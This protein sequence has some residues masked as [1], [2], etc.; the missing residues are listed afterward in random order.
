MPSWPPTSSKI[1][2]GKIYIDISIQRTEDNLK[3]ISKLV[4]TIVQERNALFC[5]TQCKRQG[6]EECQD[7]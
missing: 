1:K 4:L 2:T 7:I 3:K 6:Y 5:D